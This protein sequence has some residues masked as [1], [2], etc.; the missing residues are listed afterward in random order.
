MNR[1]RIY[2][3][4]DFPAF[5]FGAAAVLIL[6][7]SLLFGCVSAGSLTEGGKLSDW[8]RYLGLADGLVEV[9]G[10][11]AQGYCDVQA[12]TNP[13]ADGSRCQRY[14]H[15]INVAQLALGIMH[16][17]VDDWS[18]GREDQSVAIGRLKGERKRMIAALGTVATMA[19]ADGKTALIDRLGQAEKWLE[20]TSIWEPEP[21][22]A[23]AN[24]AAP[25]VGS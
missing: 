15:Y 9:G 2:S 11:L 21:V 16:G 24:L 22:V 25:D 14:A 3:D 17:I 23:T 18:S 13:T 1:T 19:K 6:V 7:L 4:S 20:G 10:A 5:D 8:S 12:V